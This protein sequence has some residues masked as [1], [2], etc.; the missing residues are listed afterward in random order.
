MYPY[1]CMMKL[2]L[3]YM[4]S[5]LVHKDQVINQFYQFIVHFI[6]MEIKHLRV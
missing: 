5:S 3:R 4:F 1:Q 2:Q 6:I